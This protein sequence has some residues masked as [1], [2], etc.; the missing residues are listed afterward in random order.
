MKVAILVSMFAP[1]YGISK[2]AALQAGS[3]ASQGHQVSIFALRA[4]M[5]PPPGVQ[6]EILGMPKG[7]LT[8]KA[9]R[10]LFPLNLI[11]QIRWVRKLSGFAVAYSH[12]YPMNWL[13]YLAKKLSGTKYVYYHHHFDLPE[14]FP[15]LL[16]RWYTRL[17]F[18][19]EK[20]TVKKADAVIAISQFSARQ[21][22]ELTGLDS[23][24]IY[25]RIDSQKFRP[26]L[27]GN[28]IREKHN[29]ANVPI[30]LF[31]GFVAPRKR[32]ELLIQVLNIV[33]QQI[34]DVRLL[35]VGRH[36]Y[37][38][39][40]ERLRRMAD[41]SVVFAGEVSEEDIPHYYAAADVCA[42]ASIMEGFNLFLAEAQACGKPVIAFDIGAHREVVR[43]ETTAVLVPDGDTKAMAAAIV[44]FLIE[45]NA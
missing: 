33:K 5:E 11:G 37:R 1:F 39:Y 15:T 32:I 34:P 20:W 22:R 14:A 44:K 41:S 19:M 43:E 45:R 31:V 12:D 17:R 40:S 16:E 8:E 21:I 23:E 7:F 28:R 29:L 9:F 13:A 10:L 2:V 35:I 25:N 36:P 38:D 18:L 26:G 24:V 3:F 30:I 6:L 42:T 27:D 4:E